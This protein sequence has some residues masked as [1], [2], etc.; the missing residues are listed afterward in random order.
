MLHITADQV[1]KAYAVFAPDVTDYREESAIGHV[2]VVSSKG[3]KALTVQIERGH[4]HP[5]GATPD[6]HGV[7]FSVFTDH[8]TSVELL[9]FYECFDLEP[10]LTIP[11]DPTRNKTFQFWH[12]YVRG[13]KPG[14]HYAYR[15]G[16]DED[17]RG[18]GNRFNRNKVLIDPY[19]RGNTSILWD[20]VAACGLE[21][22]LTTS[23]RSV[24]IDIS[25]YDWEG[26]RPLRR[27]MNE[28]IIYEMH[29][30]GFTQSPSSNCQH[31]GTFAGIIEKIPYLQDLGIT[32][33]ELL[34]VF[35]FD[36]EEVKGISPIDGQPLTNYWGYDPI[37]FFAP[38]N[39]YCISPELGT[40]LTEFRNM[41][42]ALHR[43][44]IEVILDVVFNHTSEGDHRG[45]TISLKGFANGCYYM[46]SHE[47]R[48]YY[49]NY[50]GCGNTMYGNHPITEKLI[51]DALNFW[52][53]EMHVDGFRFDEAV[54]LCRDEKGTP[55]IYP[56][57]IWQIELSDALID[58]KVIAEAWDAAGLY[59]VG[60]FPGY[61][62]GEWNGR[63][64][65]TI[66]SFVKG[67]NGYFEGKNLVGKVADVI[68]GS[69]DI[70][71]A[72][73]ELPINSI[74]FIT[75]H[76]G[77]TLNDLVSYNYK[78]N[79]LN[80]EGNRD[81]NDNNVS[82]NCGIEGA[83]DNP[84]VEALRLRQCKNFMAILMLSQGVPMFVAGD[85]V[86]R[87][88]LGNNNAYCQD[89]SINWFDWTLTEKNWELLRFCKAMIAFRKSHRTLQRRR[90][91]S[92][93]LNERGL[94]DISWHGC[95]IYSPG[96]YDSASRALAFTL[97]GFAEEE[98]GDV[99]IHVMLNME[100][101]DLDFDVPALVGRN[102]YRVVDTAAPA[103][104]DV[105]EA[106]ES[107]PQT[108]LISGNLCNV[109]WHSIVVLVSVP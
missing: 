99:D 105:V 94:A 25:H 64:R 65:D 32:A 87:T 50:S 68:A 93:Q 103:P 16:G 59:E 96:W 53:E 97:G 58:T 26:D 20:R 60:F 66:R 69:A 8:A 1:R 4:S 109:K 41:V 79:E 61:R 75:A 54:I 44:G 95:R 39:A 104:N 34:P 18:R 90:F 72:T 3:G 46:L 7:N 10:F 14:M 22:N 92:G 51:M 5:L 101:E 52:V 77:F 73:G 13:I 89:N 35:D 30:R 36:R 82:W 88:Q 47:D 37:G 45:P 84:E 15:I 63:Y 80:G 83:T 67:D 76:D 33:V 106:G 11:L 70:F 28:S 24:I 40:Q 62:W 102:W 23:M 31:P 9:L 49:M 71:E 55:M 56:P 12:V 19:S 108:A 6:A 98:S 29:V 74:N 21:D 38:E 107:L 27:P 57:V 2:A 78:H 86:R 85:E 100:W 17:I 81:G 42:K 48:Y 91:F 43:A